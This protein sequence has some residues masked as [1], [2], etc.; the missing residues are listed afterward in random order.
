MLS[1]GASYAQLHVQQENC[2][3]RMKRKEVQQENCKQRMKRKE[4]QKS[5]GGQK[6]GSTDGRVHPGSSSPREVKTD[7]SKV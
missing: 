5:K 1:I 4:G 6:K 2:K 3:Q 7:P